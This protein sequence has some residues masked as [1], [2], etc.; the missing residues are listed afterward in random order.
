MNCS[1]IFLF[2]LNQRKDQVILI[3]QLEIIALLALFSSA[4]LR[5]ECSSKHYG[6]NPDLS[7]CYA[8][9]LLLRHFDCLY[10]VD[11]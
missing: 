9:Y 8:Y 3:P 2:N 6:S 11:T 1:D 4:R 5:K 10:L 7:N